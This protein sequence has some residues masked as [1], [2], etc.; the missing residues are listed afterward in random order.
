[1]LSSPHTMKQPSRSPGPRK[2]LPAPVQK[3]PYHSSPI[4]GTSTPE[5]IPVLGWKDIC[6]RVL[7]SI[8]EDRI[9][10]TSGGVAFFALLAIFP[11]IA[12][13]VSLYGLFADASTIGAQ[14][15]MLAGVL[16]GGV[17]QLIL[18]QIVQVTEKGAPTLSVA[19]TIG[20]FIAFWTANSG[21]AA[22]FDALNVAYRE[23]EKRSVGVL[24]ATTFLFTLGAV[25]FVLAALV[26]VVI[27]P[28]FLKFVGAAA[29]VEQFIVLLRWPCLLVF[30]VLGL[31]LIYRYGPSRQIAKYRW[32]TWG[33]IAATILWIAAS[34]LF[35]SYVANF[36]SYNK[37]YGSLGAGVGFMSWIWLSV[38]II[39]LGAKLNAEIEH[40]TAKDT[41]EGAPRPLGRRGA[42]MADHVGQ[43]S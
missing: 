39:L 40:Q 34:M 41:T 9:L 21:M 20:F 12:T 1:M 27:V 31:A 18:D 14:L 8:P 30:M 26:A 38:V 10:T 25:G 13:V 5:Q 6:S 24:Y 23:K 4:P 37:T 3:P 28:L 15:A 17:L 36:D 7:W 42:S 33:S 19:F 22:L 32:L 35:S 43:S 2:G 16:P 29:P 11:A